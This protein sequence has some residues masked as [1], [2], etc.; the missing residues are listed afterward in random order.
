MPSPSQA[1][2]VP[3]P[4]DLRGEAEEAATPGAA[5]PAPG[6]R[7]EVGRGSW[8]LQEGR[9]GTRKD[10]LRR[11]THRVSGS[12]P[13]G[14]AECPGIAPHG[15]KKFPSNAPRLAVV[16][17]HPLPGT[18]L[19]PPWDPLGQIGGASR[20]R[21]RLDLPGTRGEP[22]YDS[23]LLGPSPPNSFALSGPPGTLSMRFRQQWGVLASHLLSATSRAGQPRPGA[24][25][26][27]RRGSGQVRALRPLSG[28]AERE[29]SGW[30]PGGAIRS[31]SLRRGWRLGVL[32]L[33][34][35]GRGARLSPPD[36]GSAARS[37]L[38]RPRRRT[39]GSDRSRHRLCRSLPRVQPGM[40]RGEEGFPSA[41][42]G[43]PLPAR[44]PAL[45]AAAAATTTSGQHS[46]SHR[47]PAGGGCDAARR[48]TGKEV[49]FKPRS[50]GGGVM[51]VGGAVCTC[52]PTGA[53]A[54]GQERRKERASHKK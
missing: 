46:Q 31:S 22:G 44:T 51:E 11:A 17:G 1:T 6:T 54:G 18:W 4:S 25:A 35:P 42:L 2:Q 32:W 13:P 28:L 26:W 43:F 52:W 27:A 33:R 23:L 49:T 50:R 10:W 29:V 3:P 30:I 39:R 9:S 45:S 21:L 12:G 48:G 41:S 5:A 8:A 47:A 7:W 16:G 14:G 19:F 24:P 34:T 36:A 40:G 53:L 37:L 15:L 38:L 20:R